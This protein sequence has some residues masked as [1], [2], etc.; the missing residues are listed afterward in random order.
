MIKKLKNRNQILEFRSKK[1]K[2]AAYIIRS[3][4]FISLPQNEMVSILFI[5][6]L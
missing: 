5:F 1:L 3:S 6:I 2:N 4:G